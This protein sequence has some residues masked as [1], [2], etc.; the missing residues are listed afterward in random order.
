MYCLLRAMSLSSTRAAA[1]RLASAAAGGGRRLLSSL[2]AGGHQQSSTKRAMG[3]MVFG[4]LVGGTATLCTWQ[5][6]RYYWKLE[7]IEQR[8]KDLRREPEPLELVLDEMAAAAASTP[9]SASASAAASQSS[10]LASYGGDVP[11]LRRVLLRGTWD[12]ARSILVGRRGAPARGA[13]G[14]RGAALAAPWRRQGGARLVHLLRRRLAPHRVQHARRPHP[15][16]PRR[17]EG[18]APRAAH[19]GPK[20]TCNLASISGS[21]SLRPPGATLQLA[22]ILASMAVPLLA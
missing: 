4:S 3:F 9:A 7:A 14:R 5:T 17:P 15:R 18:Q 10:V 21:A 16:H 12:H 8:K 11:T 6:S 22:L 1:A 2:P 13:L 19:A 20:Y